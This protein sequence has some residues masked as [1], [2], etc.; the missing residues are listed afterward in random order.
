[1]EVEVLHQLQVEEEQL[2]REEEQL[3]REEE[4]LQREEEEQLQREEEEEV[5]P[6]EEEEEGPERSRARRTELMTPLRALLRGL[7]PATGTYGYSTPCPNPLQLSPTGHFSA[8][9][10]LVTINHM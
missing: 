7:L 10:Y 2:Q 4:Q 1:V 8:T 6:S 5:Q 3:Q 9:I